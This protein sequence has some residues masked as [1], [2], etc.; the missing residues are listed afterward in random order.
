MKEEKKERNE[1]KEEGKGERGKKA[2][3]LKKVDMIQFIIAFCLA[4][5]YR[6]R[7][8][9]INL[10]KIQVT[11]AWDP[12]RSPSISILKS[13]FP[14]SLSTSYPCAPPHHQHTFTEDKIRDDIKGLDVDRRQD[15]G[16]RLLWITG[17]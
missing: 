12:G 1:M 13:A 2:K 15:H 14:S 4:K 6:G 17:G 9:Y 5:Y 7:P 3:P 10:E 16:D 11:I 8:C